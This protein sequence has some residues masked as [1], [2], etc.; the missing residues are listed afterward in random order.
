MC[1]AAANLYQ[2]GG[3]HTLRLYRSFVLL[4]DQGTS[5]ENLSL[6]ASLTAQILALVLHSTMTSLSLGFLTREMGVFYQLQ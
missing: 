3:C 5:R 1:I 6:G 2:E 4:Y